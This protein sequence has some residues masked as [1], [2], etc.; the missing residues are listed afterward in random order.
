MKMW[1]R[2]GVMIL[3]LSDI[4]KARPQTTEFPKLT[5]LYL[6]QTP[7][8]TTPVLFAPGMVSTGY[9]EHSSPVFT[10]DLTE[11]YWSTIIE[12]NGRTV[13]RP[14]YYMKMTNG[15]WSKPQIP[16][17]GK[18]FLCCENPFIS[19]D[20]KRLYFA[21]SNTLPPKEFALYYVNRVG[22]E[23][24]EPVKMEK[25]LNKPGSNEC[26]PTIAKSGTIYFIGTYDKSKA[27]FG[28]YFSK[29]EKGTHQ[30][31]VLMDERFNNL[32]IDWTPYIAPDERYI[33]FSSSREGEFG[34]GDLYI[35]FRQKDGSWGK[36]MNMG[37]KINTEAQER[38]PNVSPDGK[39]LF[40][41][42]TQKIPGA[43]ANGPGNGKGDVYWVDAGV[44]EDL[45]K[46]E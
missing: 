10:P 35:C 38:F 17:F 26:Q 20:G 44:I 11:I 7:P 12:E 25:P 45:R 16:T 43:D 14:T 46:A 8:E 3:L 13:S 21:A 18:N 37:N 2:I 34:D 42:R 5:G 30:K 27:G 22:T 15:I 41:N 19:P 39:Y 32:V 6:E 1:I 4:A 23:W 33:I 9:F 31:P 36:V 29:Y 24:S 40:F 28:L